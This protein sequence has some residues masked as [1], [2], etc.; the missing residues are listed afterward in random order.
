[1]LI[2][3]FLYQIVFLT[4]GVMLSLFT[5]SKAYIS[6]FQ[7]S[8]NAPFISYNSLLKFNRDKQI[9]YN[10]QIVLSILN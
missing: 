3:L 5:N 9:L 6:Q 10:T 7:Q 2:Y 8:I 4:T 1:M